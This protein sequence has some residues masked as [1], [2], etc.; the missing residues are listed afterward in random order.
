MTELIKA[1]H[2]TRNLEGIARQGAIVA[3]YNRGNDKIWFMEKKR[4]DSLTEKFAKA[5]RVSHEHG[6]LR[7]DIG[8]QLDEVLANDEALADIVQLYGMH[9]ISIEER[10][11]YRELNRILFIYLACERSTAAAYVGTSEEGRIGALLE[12]NIPKSI[13]RPSVQVSIDS[14]NTIE[15]PKEV[16]LEYLQQV[17]VNGPYLERARQ[18]LGEH[19]FGNIP[20]VELR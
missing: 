6:T 13:I 12:V 7:G 15:V 9:S 16:S 17:A 19:G 14:F 3:Y 18:I 1:Y 11:D 4:Y 10:S 20:I 5:A 2:G 8:I